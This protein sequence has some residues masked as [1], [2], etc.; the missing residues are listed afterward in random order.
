[1]DICLIDSAEGTQLCPESI[2]GMLWLQTHFV[3]DHWDAIASKKVILSTT[4][5]QDL[6]EDAQRAGLSINHLP[7]LA[8]RRKFQKNN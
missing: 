3:N 8:V 7:S 4:D 2:H 6:T 5:A 1:M